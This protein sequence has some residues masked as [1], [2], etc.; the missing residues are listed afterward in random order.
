MFQVRCRLSAANPPAQ[1]ANLY[2]L[3]HVD[4][5]SQSPTLAPWSLDNEWNGSN[6]GRWQVVFAYS[7]HE[8]RWRRWSQQGWMLFLYTTC[9]AQIISVCIVCHSFALHQLTDIFGKCHP[10]Y[11][12]MRELHDPV[13]ILHFSLCFQFSSNTL[14]TLLFSPSASNICAALWGS[15]AR[16]MPS[17]LG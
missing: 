11:K 9:R 17:C 4:S 13:P 12:F 2:F 14:D 15:F 8:S 7:L 5:G 10:A 1:V 3:S 16:L 6:G